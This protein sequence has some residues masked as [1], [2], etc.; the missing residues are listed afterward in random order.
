M[1][2]FIKSTSQFFFGRLNPSIN[3]FRR[4]KIVPRVTLQF[5]ELNTLFIYKWAY[6]ELSM[7]KE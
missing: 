5:S 3:Y 6:H 4:A 1:I 7:V 2:Y